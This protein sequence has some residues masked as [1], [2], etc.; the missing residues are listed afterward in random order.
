MMKRFY[1]IFKSLCAVGQGLV[2]SWWR[3]R[4]RRLGQSPP[5]RRA[6]V[7]MGMTLET[8]SLSLTLPIETIENIENGRYRSTGLHPDFLMRVIKD[9]G[10]FLHV[11]AEAIEAQ[12][13]N[14]RFASDAMMPVPGRVLSVPTQ[15]PW[16][17]QL[18]MLVTSAVLSYI[19]FMGGW[20]IFCERE[21]DCMSLSYLNTLPSLM[22]AEISEDDLSQKRRKCAIGGG[23]HD[24]PDVP[25][26]VDL[27]VFDGIDK[28]REILAP[29]KELV[30]RE[31]QASPK[32]VK[33]VRVQKQVRPKAA[34]MSL[35][36][37]LASA[38]TKKTKKTEAPQT[39]QSVDQGV[40]APKTTSE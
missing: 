14:I 34:P 9:Y 27:E 21:C 33:T 39:S 16:R 37:L 28:Q 10:A 12:V 35:D 38:D 32:P 7:A 17:T 24:V 22:L 15:H 36:D 13:N 2:L 30:L 29:K 26:A 19:V 20:G 31:K 4:P 40:Q 23:C 25:A 8:A 11:D 1:D 3:R 6:R 18:L 5:F